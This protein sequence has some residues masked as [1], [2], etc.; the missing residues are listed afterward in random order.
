MKVVFVKNSKFVSFDKNNINGYNFTPRR[1]NINSLK[2][3]DINII[4]YILNKKL[5]RDI[6]K[7]DKTIKLMI[8]SNVTIVSDCDMME[9]ELI[10]VINIIVSKYMKYFDEFEFFLYIKKIYVLN[11]VLDLKKKMIREVV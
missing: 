10:R 9:K 8:D 3:V 7:I 5:N 6:K 1:K 4:K 2:I 11:R